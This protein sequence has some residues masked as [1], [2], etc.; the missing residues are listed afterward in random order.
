[1]VATAVR[2]RGGRALS[3]TASFYLSKWVGEGAA[4][5]RA[6]FA[7]LDASFAETGVRSLLV[8]DELEAIALD[9]SQAWTLNRGHLD[10][11]DTLLE[12]LTHSQTRMIGISNVADRFLDT[13]LVRDGR[14][15]ILRFP[16]ALEPEQVTALV[17]RC[18]ARVPL[19]A[20][21]GAP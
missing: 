21:G 15:P 4:H 9:R 2:A 18:L 7:L 8:I 16:P 10:V 17:A 11:L 14:L 20:G 6:D 12:R 19:A 5:L 13:A 1:M 3:R